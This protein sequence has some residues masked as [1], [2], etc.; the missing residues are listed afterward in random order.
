MV[1]AVLPGRH[2][3]VAEEDARA[4]MQGRRD[5]PLAAERTAAGTPF[6]ATEKRGLG[7]E[8]H[9]DAPPGPAPDPLLEESRDDPLLQQVD[10]TRPAPSPTAL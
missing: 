3:V 2:E 8:Q 1:R 4:Q 10:V 6:R 5:A 9:I 7:V